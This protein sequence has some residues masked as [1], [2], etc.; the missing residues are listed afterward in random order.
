LFLPLP[1]SPGELL[2]RSNSPP[3]APQI[4]GKGPLSGFLVEQL[5]CHAPLH[6]LAFAYVTIQNAPLFLLPNRNGTGDQLE[7]VNRILLLSNA[8]EP[9]A[10][11]LPALLT[12]TQSVP[13]QKSGSPFVSSPSRQPHRLP[14][15]SQRQSH[16]ESSTYQIR[17]TTTTT[18]TLPCFPNPRQRLEWILNAS[19]RTHAGRSPFHVTPLLLKSRTSIFLPLNH[20]SRRRRHMSLTDDLLRLHSVLLLLPPTPMMRWYLTKV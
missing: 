6:V 10:V 4:S 19:H 14:A 18:P 17:T 13:R 3:T 20:S 15:L 8:S 12:L 2:V 11:L 1:P 5:E 7:N 16:P 9:F